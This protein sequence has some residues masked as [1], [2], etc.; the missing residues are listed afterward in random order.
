MKL[1]KEEAIERHRLMWNWIA[2]ET[3]HKQKCFDKLDAFYISM[4]P[5]RK[6]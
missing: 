6:D 2:E 5:E 3:L 1:T 4:L